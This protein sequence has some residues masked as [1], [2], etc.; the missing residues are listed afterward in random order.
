M[1]EKDLL[2]ADM[3]INPTKYS[4]EEMY[5]IIYNG[6]LTEQDLVVNSKVLTKRAYE[7]ILRYPNLSDEQRPLPVSTLK[8]P[9]S[10][11]GNVDVY[12]I[13]L[14]GSG[15]SCLLGGLMAQTGN[16]GFRFNPRGPGGGGDY[17]MELRNYL[18]RGWLPPTDDQDYIKVIDC[19]M[20]SET[21]HSYKYS[22]IEMPGKKYLNL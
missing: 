7:H 8:E 10:E 4:R 2:L 14:T 1:S 22:F 6:I 3:Q 9:K 13:G 19:E 17:A 18:R 11:S 15:K 20:N 16:L 12:F 21:G 5:R